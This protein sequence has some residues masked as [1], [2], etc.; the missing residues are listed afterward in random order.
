M[1]LLHSTTTGHRGGR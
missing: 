1:L